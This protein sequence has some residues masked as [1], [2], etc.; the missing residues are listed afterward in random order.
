MKR[1]NEEKNEIEEIAEK[2]NGQEERKNQNKK[3]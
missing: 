3:V 2:R 1:I